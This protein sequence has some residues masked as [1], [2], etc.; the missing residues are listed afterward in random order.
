ML[1]EE[2]LLLE[3]VPLVSGFDLFFISLL[4]SVMALTFI[5]VNTMT[6]LLSFF[7]QRDCTHEFFFKCVCFSRLFLLHYF[8]KQLLLIILL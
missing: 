5:L 4:W 7:L 1:Q 6:A 3:I 8:N 2:D